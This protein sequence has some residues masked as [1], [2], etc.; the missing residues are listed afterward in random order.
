MANTR[1]WHDRPRVG[2]NTPRTKGR[3]ATMDRQVRRTPRSPSVAVDSRGKE[4]GT[5]EMSV[6]RL[7]YE[8]DSRRA[9]TSLGGPVL[10]LGRD[11][12]N[13]AAT[14]GGE[15]AG[16]AGSAV[17]ARAVAGGD[18]PAATEVLARGGG[19][20]RDRAAGVA[21]EVGPGPEAGQGVSGEGAAGRMGCGVGGISGFGVGRRNRTAAREAR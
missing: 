1:E 8:D 13:Q 9:G 15:A 14:R 7:R 5:A 16:R 11:A 18:G 4:G 20:D 19:E 12:R 2:S 3:K 21:G 10:R 17:R 6:Q